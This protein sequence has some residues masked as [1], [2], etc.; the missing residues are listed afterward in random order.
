MGAIRWNAMRM[1][2]ALALAVG[3]LLGLAVWVVAWSSAPPTAQAQGS[4]IRYVAP[5]GAD[6]GD[7]A[8]PAQPCATVQYAVDQAAWGDEVHIATGVYTDV[9]QRAGITQTVY[10][11]KTVALRGGYPAG[12]SG[13]PDP[14][15]LPTT[16][17]AQGRGRVL[18]IAGAI[19]PTVEGLRIT[20]GNAAGL[21][22]PGV[23]WDDGGGVLILTATVTLCDSQ[24]FS[25]TANH[26]GGLFLQ[27]G[28][29]AISNN[30]F[31]GN[32]ASYCS[33]GGLYVS[34]SNAT[35]NSNIIAGN[36][37]TLGGGRFLPTSEASILRKSMI[38]AEMAECA[39][40]G[41]LLYSSSATVNNNIISGNITEYDGGGVF[42]S[43]STATLNGNTVTTNTARE[44]GGGLCLY[45]STAALHGNVVSANTAE[46]FTGGGL[47][48]I[49][50][51]VVLDSNTVTG[52]VAKYGGG[53]ALHDSD[54]ISLTNNIIAGNQAIVAGGGLYI[55][56]SSPR[57][58]HT[59]IAGNYSG[60]GSGVYIATSWFGPSNVALT[61]TIVVSHTVG[62]TVAA[63]STVTLG[64]TLWGTGA[65]ANGTDWAGAG[66]IVT[67]TR[68]TW[69]DPAFLNPAAGNYHIGPS[70]AARDMGVNAGVYTDI[71]GEPRPYQLPDIGADEY[72]P[73]GALQ[74][75]YLPLVLRG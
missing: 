54:D 68:N 35:I 13:P 49:A 23:V 58:Q 62:I 41:I 28:A 37:A 66:T 25:N 75:L 48:L 1:H 6:A 45:K 70:S 40:G 22:G 17:D 64:A 29:A 11:T 36:L 9:H 52:C 39:G 53:L 10:L 59:T 14:A 73:P 57:L 33:G 44:L 27:S 18:Y 19:S 42:L 16:L 55:Q 30:T 38:I 51:V 60:D 15:A 61:N 32:T 4:L 46:Y 65:W 43:Y 24:V 2:V 31:S 21:G 72:W 3:S 47:S 74:R 26:G 7:C 8:D 12:F 63:G 20:G 5:T 71:D 69:G 50:S 34:E 56:T 67:G